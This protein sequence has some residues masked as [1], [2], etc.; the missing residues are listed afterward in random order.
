MPPAVTSAYL[1]PRLPVIGSGISLSARTSA[2]RLRTLELASGRA[3]FNAARFDEGQRETLGQSPREFPDDAL[4]PEIAQCRVQRLERRFGEPIDR[5]AGPSILG[6]GIEQ[7]PA[8]VE[9]GRAGE[10]E[11]RAEHRSGERLQTA[12]RG[13]SDGDGRLGAHA[14]QRQQVMSGRQQQ[15]DQ[16]GKD[17]LARRVTE[18]P[19]E[20]VAEPV[21]AR[22]GKA[23]AAGGKDHAL[24]GQVASAAVDREV[25]A[26]LGDPLDSP[27]VKDRRPGR[28]GGAEQR[29]EHRAG[30]VGDREELAGLLALERDADLAEEVHGLRHVEATQD[31]SNGRGRGTGEGPFVDGVMGDVAAAASRDEDLGPQLASAVERDHAPLGSATSRVDC[32]HQ[33][34]RP[35]SD[36]CDVRVFGQSASHCTATTST[37]VARAS[38]SMSGPGRISQERC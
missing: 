38:S 5:E 7:K 16:R 27:R 17:L 25:V 12:A 18:M 21:R 14:A 4:S 35:R 1:K 28:A 36:H 34:G 31:A 33:A 30:A 11:V 2:R 3:G 19:G 8:D 24:R 29:V 13:R 37:V 23:H 10:A 32:R 20:V 15:R 22:L 9:D 26:L 6:A